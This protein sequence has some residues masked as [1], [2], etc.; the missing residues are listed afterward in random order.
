M[1]KK[2]L[3]TLFIST[4]ALVFGIFP[5]SNLN[6]VK[7]SAAYDS[8]TQGDLPTT[9][10]FSDLEPA[11][12]IN[13]Y[14]PL[15]SLDNSEKTG[16]NLLK[17]LKPILKNNQKY[18]GYD[19]P[20]GEAIW[21]M[22][23]IIDRDWIKSPISSIT[24]GSYNP[25]T[26]TLTGY[27]YGKDNPYIHA[28]YVNRNVENETKA[29][30]NHEQNQWGINREHIWP[31]SAGFENAGKGGA[32]GD[33]MHLWAGNGRVNGVEHSNYFYGYVD[34]TKSYTDPVSARGWTNL[35]GNYMGT[36]KTLGGTVSVFEPQD[37]DKGDIARAVFYMVARYNYLSG[38]DDDGI[39]Q[40]N[41]NLALTQNLLDWQN[42]GYMS[43]TT[44]TGK[45]GI[46]SDLLEWNRLDPPD[47]W[48][49]H[50]NNLVYNNYSNNRNPFVDYPEWADICWGSDA[51][52]KYADPEHD[53][54]NGT[55][56]EEVP[57]TGLSLNKDSVTLTSGETDSLTV[58]FEPINATTRGVSWST[59][60]SSVA[61]V[62]NGII[63]AKSVGSA[64]ITATSDYNNSIYASC[65]V[66]VNAPS[67]DVE[68]FDNIYGS[69]KVYTGV[70]TEGNYLITYNN[71]AMKAS[72]S[73]ERLEYNTISPL[74]GKITITDDENYDEELMVW[75]IAPSGDYWTI[76]NAN[77]DK[78]AASTGARNKA[79]LL[80]SDTDDKSL[81]TV[82]GTN[83]YEF[84]NKQ[85][86]VNDVNKNLR[87]NTTY[88][89][90][91][92]STSTGDALTLYRQEKLSSISLTTNPTSEFELNDTFVF[93]G[94]VTATF[95]TDTEV[96]ITND[97]VVTGY[98]M[99]SGGIQ[100]ITISYTFNG[101]AKGTTYDIN[102]LTPVVTSVTLSSSKLH[103]D[104]FDD[105]T[106]IL[107]ASL[108]GE[109]NP[110]T[111]VYW[112][113]E[114]EG[115][116]TVDQNGNVT[117]VSVGITN[118][119]ATSVYDDSQTGICEV[120]VVDSTP[121]EEGTSSSTTF[122]SS[123]QGFTNAYDVNG[124]EYAFENSNFVVTFNKGTGSSTPKYYS[125]GYSIRA[126]GGN[127]FAI[128]CSRAIISKIVLTIASGGGS[129]EITTN[130][131]TYN[132]GVWTGT[133]TNSVIFSIGGTTGHRRI[134]TIEVFYYSA[135]DFATDFL[136][137]SGCDPN[138]VNAPTIDW[139]E[140]NNKYDLLFSNEQTLLRNASLKEDGTTIERAM[141]RYNY[142]VYKY[143]YDN[144]IGRTIKPY[145]NPVNPLGTKNELNYSVIIIAT[146]ALSA[147]SL[148]GAGLLLIKKKER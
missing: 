52:V 83:A 128:E 59:D 130:K 31:K 58:S 78:Y 64:V 74:N 121:S 129:N 24:S 49:I 126:Y 57:L 44:K 133:L 86:D 21:K 60:N 79:Q 4:A 8:I 75:H 103:L 19:K 105:Q 42:S 68:T 96:D 125:A 27:V 88:G 81:W 123:E 146:I 104:L 54:I 77:E 107:T 45:L 93:D 35:S 127:N 25:I 140:M 47:E 137:N 115:I 36:S 30:G 84:V 65:T 55:E 82:T 50:R 91:C 56:H 120:T 111:D 99:S 23:E 67:G 135:S 71:G 92:Y 63:T 51:G 15:I 18:Y 48:E 147:V 7:K 80:A 109:H 118:V 136:N 102:V 12:I 122:V 26:K 132:D 134:Q 6:K 17:N 29:W 131:G 108:T 3:A 90:A 143:D 37:S 148:V 20:Y 116:A 144:F 101:I 141:T 41:P 94:T 89:F 61:T 66:I 16:M 43:S 97:V 70:L 72:V 124:D 62:S 119:C 76:Y 98:D 34:R 69:Y 9:L 2:L 85:N 95:G 73:N 28:L 5:N 113:S 87:R 40:D 39:D 117:A 14:S 139:E 22:Y 145:N 33:P 114:D 1:N 110:P 142:I 11:E 46:V 53:S 100:T 38:S 138:G 13:Y 112:Y 10:N 32:R 106:A